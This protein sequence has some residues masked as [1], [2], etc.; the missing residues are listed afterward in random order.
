MAHYSFLDELVWFFN[1]FFVVVVVLV[2]FLFSFGGRLQGW[3]AD[4]KER[5]DEWD[6]VHDVKLHRESIKGLKK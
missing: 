2:W 5:G 3:R 1:T 4:M 6:L